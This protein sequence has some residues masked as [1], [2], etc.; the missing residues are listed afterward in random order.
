MS[1]IKSNPGG[2][3][4]VNAI[5]GRDALVANVWDI[6]EQQS[7]ILTAE[8]RIG[9]TQVL[10]KMEA[11]APDNWATVFTDLEK[12]HTA[13]DFARD[14]YQH[15]SRHLSLGKRSTNLARKFL[16]DLGGTSVG[17]MITLPEASWKPFLI[18]CI[19]DLVSEQRDHRLVFC[20]DEM[21]YMLDNIRQR[22]GEAV[23]MEVLDVLRS[24]RQEHPNFRMVLTG[25][26]GLHH[27]LTSLKE[28]GYRNA[29]V[30]DMHSIEVPPLDDEH[31]RELAAALIQGEKLPSPDLH[32]A[33]AAIATAADC[34]PFYIHH[35]V[36]RL[37]LTGSQAS[38]EDIQQAVTDQMHDANDP[39]EL[40]HYRDRI[41]AYYPADT[42]VVIAILDAVATASQPIAVDDVL[43]QVS[44]Q[45][46]GF[47]DREHLLALLRLMDRDHYLLRD[48]AGYR[49]RFPLIA[50][51]WRLDRDLTAPE[52]AQP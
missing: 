32:E 26:I 19:T 43:Q 37:K 14:V 4:P 11:M 48:P 7:I 41:C 42:Q 36:R 20:W 8:R 49:M 24:L 44:S 52:A 47:N 5:V 40:A 50:R 28:L 34:V 18:H 30:N 9:K 31:A 39:W 33:A 6:L 45:V 35:I 23:A 16:Q 46:E 15:V 51:W 25:S 21:P 10:R 38:P 27:V 3:I 1:P 12:V 13:A 29:P 22:E 2:P 17:S